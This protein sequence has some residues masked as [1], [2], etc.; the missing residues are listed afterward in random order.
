MQQARD[1]GFHPAQ[2]VF[3]VDS[4]CVPSANLRDELHSD[5]V[6]HR[7]NRDFGA[8]TRNVTSPGECHPAAIVVPCLEFVPGAAAAREEQV[9]DI[10]SIFRP[11]EM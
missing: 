5:E 10:C 6:Q 7:I 8:K 9:H 1:D 2:A 11:P 4:D 3:L